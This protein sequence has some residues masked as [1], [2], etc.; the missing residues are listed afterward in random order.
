MLEVCNLIKHFGGLKA[1]D[2]LG[3]EVK[4]G[5]IVGLIGPNGAGK[6]TV[7]NMIAGNLKP[8]RGKI[9][10]HGHDITKSP[11]YR[12]AQKRISRVFQRNILFHSFDVLDNVL[13]AF[14]LHSKKTILE[15]L[16]E[17]AGARKR[18]QAEYAKAMEIL[19]FLG[20]SQHAN[21]PAI[22]LPHGKQRILSL[23]IA[24]ATDP[25]LM[26]LDEPL[27]GMNAEETAD[28]M[29]IIKSLR[30]EKN[31][32]SIVVEHNI[33]A[34]LGICDRLL[35]LNY[36]KKIA[37]GLPSQVVEQPGVIEAYLGAEQDVT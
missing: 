29:L 14:H 3:F 25:E 19:Q 10:L 7:L 32:T 18:K 8:T 2:D 15:I 24:L 4:K 6:S 21:E 37:E 30:D 33:K 28:M 17:N 20:L 11:S 31:I 5:S 13:T 34:V 27:A 26:L 9:I 16:Y 22:N 36:G 23:A 1:V 12:K 35:V